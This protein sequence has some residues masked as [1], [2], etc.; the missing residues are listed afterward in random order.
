MSLIWENHRFN[1]VGRQPSNGEFI[2]GTWWSTTTAATD[3]TAAILN[4]CRAE[5]A[6]STLH[7]RLSNSAFW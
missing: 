1:F 4:P 5:A 3:Y 6:V 7:P 2:S